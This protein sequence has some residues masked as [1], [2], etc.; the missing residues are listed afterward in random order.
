MSGTLAGD[1]ALRH[2]E[3]CR[4]HLI[5]LAYRMLGTMSEAEDIVQEAFLRWYRDDRRTVAAP[6][7]YLSRIV[8]RLSLDHL[9]SARVKRESYVG[10]WLPEPLIQAAI[11][12]TEAATALADD[13]SVAMLLALER[14]SPLERAAFLLHDVFD[15]PFTAVAETLGRNEAACRQLVVRA[16]RHVRDGRPRFPVSAAEG[17]TIA[18]AFFS[19]S[20]S[21]DVTGLQRLL[22]DDVV[23]YTDGGGRRHAAIRPIFGRDRVT[24][25]FAGL[26]RKGLLGGSRLLRQC[27]INSLPGFVSIEAD[28]IVQTT[29]F[30]CTD[31]V[32]T[33]VYVV[34][35][36]D[37]L[38][39]LA[40]L[41]PDGFAQA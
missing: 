15:L 40:D 30:A 23:L 17:A 37:K 38:G 20:R 7:A 24:R 28:G 2:F 34:R 10:V 5:G 32:I 12:G 29:A 9:K 36:P 4:P 14:L 11:D 33:A 1:E 25:L 41:A 22:A 26:V 6:R 19:A 31:G 8:T 27:T 18:Q 13:L 21:G 16:R 3:T 35:N 39:H